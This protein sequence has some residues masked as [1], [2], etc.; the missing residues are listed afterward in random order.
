MTPRIVCS[1]TVLAA[2]LFLGADQARAD[3]IDFSYSWTPQPAVISS[4]TGI[5]TVSAAADGSAQATLGSP[6]ATSIPGATLTTS[7]SAGIDNTP[8]DSFNTTYGLKLHL[9]DT[10]SGQSGDLTF[11]AALQGTLTSTNSTLTSTFQGP[12]TQTLTLNGHIYSVTIDPSQTNVP[13]P[14]D[15][16]PAQVNALVTV[17]NPSTAPPPANAPEPASLFLGATAVLGMAAGR[18]LRRRARLA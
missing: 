10:A 6:T 8:A 16:Q 14:G 7:S 1:A 13:P 12:L 9:T 5:V 11:T 2:L 4:G 17:T 3:L 15:S 18:I